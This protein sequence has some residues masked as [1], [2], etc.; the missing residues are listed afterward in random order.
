MNNQNIQTATK[1]F[2]QTIAI[3]LTKTEIHQHARNKKIFRG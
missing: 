1:T 3:G 2:R